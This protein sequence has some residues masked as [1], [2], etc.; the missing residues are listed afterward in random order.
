MNYRNSINKE[1][2]FNY[3]RDLKSLMKILNII[4]IS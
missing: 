4:L 2:K 3:G 1:F